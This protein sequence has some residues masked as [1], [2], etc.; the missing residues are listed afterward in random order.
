MDFSTKVGDTRAAIRATLS[1]ASGA[2]LTDIK[3]VRFRMS[4][5]LF[6]NKIDRVVDDFTN[7]VATLIFTAAEVA[8]PGTYYGEFVVEYNDDTIETFPNDSYLE[9]QI[10]KN[11]G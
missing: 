8:N 11:V 7:P 1:P 9:I 5:T 4:N 3:E 2:A 6:S 10:L